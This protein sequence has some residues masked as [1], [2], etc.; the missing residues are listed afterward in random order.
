MRSCVLLDFAVSFG[1]ITSL[2]L[3]IFGVVGILRGRI[4]RRWITTSSGSLLPLG[5]GLFLLF[6]V[7]PP[8]L[9]AMGEIEGQFMLP[10]TAKEAYEQI[11]PE[12][13]QSVSPNED[14]LPEQQAAFPMWERQVMTAHDAADKALNGVSQVMKALQEGLIDRF[15][16]W[17]R[18]G[19]LSQD[20]KQADLMLHEVV[21]PAKL[22]LADQYTLEEALNLLHESL[23]QKRSGIQALQEFTQNLAP[24]RLERANRQ[25]E[26]GHESLVEALEYIGRVKGKLGL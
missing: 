11:V 19:V 5:L 21:P 24:A 16:A 17:T 12:V 15:T 4:D 26:L 6:T 25:M 18:L 2:V 9:R 7:L 8:P 14:L 22:N 13:S 10:L 1:L 3:I 20:L 23:D